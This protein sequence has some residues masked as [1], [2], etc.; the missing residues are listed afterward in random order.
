MTER[1]KLLERIKELTR[2]LDRRW[3]RTNLPNREAMLHKLEF[4]IAT[5]KDGET[6]HEIQRPRSNPDGGGNAAH[7]PKVQAG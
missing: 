7:D 2:K 6:I 5:Y 3:D 1:R 4:L